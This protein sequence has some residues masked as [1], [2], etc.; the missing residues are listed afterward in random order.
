MLDEQKIEKGLENRLK[1]E[2]ILLYFSPSSDGGIFV[3]MWFIMLSI[4]LGQGE[5]SVPDSEHR[6]EVI[7]HQST[8]L[9]EL[10]IS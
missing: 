3:L 5:G 9:E 1:L 8:S 10:I 7:F 6:F 2:K 4:I